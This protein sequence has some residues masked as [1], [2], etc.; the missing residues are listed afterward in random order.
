MDAIVPGKGDERKQRPQ[1]V[2]QPE[3]SRLMGDRSTGSI[4]DFLGRCD[5]DEQRG[6]LRDMLGLVA[7]AQDAREADTTIVD[8]R[9]IR[10]LQNFARRSLAW[11]HL[12]DGLDARDATMFRVYSMEVGMSP[13]ETL[14]LLEGDMQQAGVNVATVFNAIKTA[15]EDE[16]AVS[17][18]IEPVHVY[19]ASK[20][21]TTSVG[22]PYDGN[23]RESLLAEARKIKEETSGGVR[24]P[25][26][27]RETTYV[28]NPLRPWDSTT[29]AL[30]LA[31]SMGAESRDING[32]IQRIRGD[33]DI[34][35]RGQ[36]TPRNQEIRARYRDYIQG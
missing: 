1:D 23:N 18:G 36:E 34:I 30:E 15:K 16:D 10:G 2:K 22:S 31:F 3:V 6:R 21:I 19:L 5:N 4:Q 35:L 14:N 9:I 27:R 7:E 32:T 28:I 24:T 11:S 25:E 29:S 33:L 17:A 8:R 13:L 12:A 26:P 20:R